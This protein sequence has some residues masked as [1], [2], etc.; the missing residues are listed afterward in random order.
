MEAAHKF[1]D[2]AILEAR[3]SVSFANLNLD[4]ANRWQES[5]FVDK[6]SNEPPELTAVP[7]NLLEAMDCMLLSPPDTAMALE[8]IETFAQEIGEVVPPIIANL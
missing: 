2:G 4:A 5:N 8:F 6:L 1:R 3:S 7:G